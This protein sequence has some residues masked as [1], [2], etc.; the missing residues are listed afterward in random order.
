MELSK[1]GHRSNRQRFPGRL[2]AVTTAGTRI[3]YVA[4][5]LVAL[6]FLTNATPTQDLP[7]IGL[8]VTLPVTQPRWGHSAASYLVGMWLVEFTFPFAVLAVARRWGTTER[9][10][11]GLLLG[12]PA[13]YM[14][15]LHLYCRFHYLPAV[16]PTPLGPAATAVCWAYCATGGPAWGLVTAGVASL[17]VLAWLLA[18]RSGP[19]RGWAAI[20][21]GIL[22]L[23][24]GIPALYW[25]YTTVRPD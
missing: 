24:L 21:F 18:D 4:I 22:S 3:F 14:L 20:S 13:V 2:D 16:T 9:R 6:A 5:A 7:G 23:P 19:L 10:R 8:P 11:R 17:G 25:G 1:E 15:G 12:L